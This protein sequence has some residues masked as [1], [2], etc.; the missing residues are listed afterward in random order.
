[1]TSSVP[2]LKLLVLKFYKKLFTNFSKSSRKIHKRSSAT[3]GMA[4][5]GGRHAVGGDLRSPIW[6][7]SKAR[8]RLSISDNT[9]LYP[10][11]HRFKVT[12]DYWSNLHFDRCT[13]L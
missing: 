7:H 6:C 9:K 8:M 10:I 4:R 2:A 1:M 12:A 13:S 5:I 3:A 11:L